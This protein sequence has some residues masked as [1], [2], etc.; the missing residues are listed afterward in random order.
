MFFLLPKGP[1]WRGIIAGQAHPL[2]GAQSRMRAWPS[3]HPAV[4]SFPVNSSGA[5]HQQLTGMHVDPALVRPAFM[6]VHPRFVD[7]LGTKLAWVVGAVN[8]KG[9]LT[10]LLHPRAPQQPQ[11]A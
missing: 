5:V 3:V 7:W 11:L 1:G 8:E 4:P 2:R 6:P 10:A 9:R